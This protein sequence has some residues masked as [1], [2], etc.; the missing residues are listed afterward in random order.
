[1]PTI[2]PDEVKALIQTYFAGVHKSYP[3]LDEAEFHKV[4]ETARER[5]FAASTS[6]ALVLIVLAL[7]RVSTTVY[8][9]GGNT[10]WTPG[11][12]FSAPA[13]K[14]LLTEGLSSFG[15]SLILAQALYLCSLYYSFLSRPLQAWRFVHMAS[16]EAQH[17]WIR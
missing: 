17:L 5:K 2:I 9:K 13:M 10:E 11:S 15:N 6:S 7:A 8:L 3:V 16:T 1:M 4:Y 14:I 12:Q